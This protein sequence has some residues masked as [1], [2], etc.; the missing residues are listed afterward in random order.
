[1]PD[2]LAPLQPIPISVVT[3]FL[4]AGKTTL[5]NRLVAARAG[6]ERVGVVVNEAGEVGLDG[7]LLGDATDDV[8]EIADGCVCCTSQGE[9]LEAITRLH[10]AAGRLDRIIV[11]TSGLADPGPVIDALA[12]VTHVLRLDSI[13]TVIDTLHS[14]DQLDRI[15]SPEALAQVQLATHVVLSKIDIAD[16]ETV[17]AVRARI[18]ALN[19]AAE[20]IVTPREELDVGLL[21][22]RFSIAATDADNGDHSHGHDHEHGFHHHEHL[23]VEIFSL[24]LSGELDGGRFEGW[25]GGLIMLKAPDLFRIKAIVALAGEPHRQIVH[26]VQTYV[27]SAA[28]R[29]WEPDEERSSKIVIIGRDLE[30]PQ[31]RAELERCVVS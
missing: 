30:T 11:E 13:V 22:D 12:S 27:E 26:G 17:E 20:I 29:A 31:W 9:L 18:A 7:Q 5:V 25:L 28:G 24:E 6:N 15:K 14:I 10:R 16:A 21:L 19:P 2:Q 3:G 23:D 4:G 1:M 8:V